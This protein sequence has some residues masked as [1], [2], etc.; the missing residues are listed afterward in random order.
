M[1]VRE[2]AGTQPYFNWSTCVA[3]SVGAQ[4]VESTRQGAIDVAGRRFHRV[5]LGRQSNLREKDRQLCTA[6]RCWRTHK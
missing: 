2:N 4:L 5:L 6:L 3:L 1:A